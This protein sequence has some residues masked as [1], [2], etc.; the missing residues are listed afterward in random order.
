MA[1]KGLKLPPENE[2]LLMIDKQ[3]DMAHLGRDGVYQGIM[4]RGYWWPRLR[5]EVEQ[6]VANCD[7]CL[8]YTITKRKY[9]PRRSLSVARPGDVYAIDILTLPESRLGYKKL[10]VLVDYCSRFAVFWPVKNEE[11]EE[12]AKTLLRIFSFIGPCKILQSDN[13]PGFQ[14]ETMKAFSNLLHMHH[15][16]TI[17]YHPEANGIVERPNSTFIRMLMKMT[18]AEGVDWPE[19]A[20]FM[21]IV[22]NDHVS[23]TSGMSRF[24][25]MHGREMNEFMNYNCERPLSEQDT[26][27]AVDD[28]MKTWDKMLSVIWPAVTLKEKT[29]RRSSTHAWTNI[30]NP[31]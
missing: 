26:E 4:K 28:A 7:R 12:C 2:R 22:Y 14:N 31:C 5:R 23:W 25:L 30:E 13:G 19:L 17:E 18:E 16:F 3:H 20:P 24:F 9:H 8:H 15:R 11:A 21:Q 1:K 6:V 27:Q 10:L 29:K